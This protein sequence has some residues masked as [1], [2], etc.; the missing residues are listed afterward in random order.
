LINQFVFLS[1]SPISYYSYQHVSVIALNY[2]REI[3]KFVIKLLTNYCRIP[4]ALSR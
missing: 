1:F 4:A 2:D 3:A